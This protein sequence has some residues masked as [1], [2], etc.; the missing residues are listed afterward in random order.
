MHSSVPADGDDQVRSPFDSSS[1]EIHCILR[2]GRDV[3]GGF[4][5]QSFTDLK[6]DPVLTVGCLTP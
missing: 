6:Q 1:A 4:V 3:D 2:F 5:R